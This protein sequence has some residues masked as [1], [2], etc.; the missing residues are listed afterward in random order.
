MSEQSDNFIL[1]MKPLILFK[2]TNSNYRSR[3]RINCM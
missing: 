3:K 1:K 2:Y